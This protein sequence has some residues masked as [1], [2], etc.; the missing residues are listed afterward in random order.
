MKKSI[1]ILGS[2][3]KSKNP[4][5]KYERYQEFFMS[6]AMRGGF[7]TDIKTAFVDDLIISVGTQNFEIVDSKNE[8]DLKNYDLVVLRGAEFSRIFDV[9]MA[10]SEY[11]QMHNISLVNDYSQSFDF[12]KL[13]QAVR[14][15]AAGVPTPQTLYVSKA[16]FYQ[17]FKIPFEVPCIMKDVHGAHGN[18]NYVIESIEQALEIVRKRPEIRFIMQPFI[19]NDGDYRILL[20]GEQG[21]CIHR[22]AVEGTHLNNT[23]QGG[24]AELVDFASVDESLLQSA[25]DAAKILNMTCAGVDIIIDRQT[26]QQ[27]VLEVNSQPQL[28]SGAFLNEKKQLATDFLKTIY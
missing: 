12:S 3:Q 1:L 6:A 24:S 5:K 18:D 23:S 20:L 21:I 26:K 25:R 4:E 15:F 27:Y 17:N 7:E 16:I 28:I 9:L 10:I 14:L 8:K 19:P 2:A 11:C 13:S 22:K